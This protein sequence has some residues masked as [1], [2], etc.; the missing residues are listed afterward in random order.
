MIFI[1]YGEKEND[2]RVKRELP[3]F[4]INNEPNLILCKSDE[5]ITTALSIYMQSKEQPLPSS[6]EV[7]LCSS[8][9]KKEEVVEIF[10]RRS[11]FGE[12]G[13][14]HCLVNADLLDFDVSEAAGHFIDECNQEK[15][16][17]K[18]NKYGMVIICCRENE[19]RSPL[20]SSLE[21]Y[22]RPAIPVETEKLSQ[23]LLTKFAVNTGTDQTFASDVDFEKSNTRIVLSERAGVGKSL[24]VKR[25]EEKLRFHVARQEQTTFERVTVPL[26]ERSVNMEYVTQSLLKHATE[27]EIKTARLF[28]IDI[29]HEVQEGIDYLLFNLLVLNSLKDESGLVWKRS[30]SDIYLIEHMPRMYSAGNDDDLPKA[31]MM[32]RILPQVTCLSPSDCLIISE[33]DERTVQ[34]FDEQE[35]K[36]DVFQRPYY[37]LKG[38]DSKLD[39]KLN[40]EKHCGIPNPTWAE[41]H[42]FVWFLN[43]QLVGFE[44]NTFVGEVAVRDLPGFGQFVLRFLIL[45]SKDFSNRSLNICDE[46]YAG[47]QRTELGKYEFRRKWESSP[48]P[49]LFFNSDGVSFTF[50]GFNVDPY[51]GNLID[52]QRKIVLEKNI[53]DESLFRALIRNKVDLKEN[54]DKLPRSHRIEKLANV[55]GGYRIKD[56]DPTYELTTDNAKKIL[57][58]FM[59]FKCDIPVIVMGETGCGKTRLIKFMCSLQVPEDRQLQNTVVMKVLSAYVYSNTTVHGGTTYADIERKVNEADNLAR[60][61]SKHGLNIYTVLFFDEA[62]TTEAIGLLKEIMCDRTLRGLPLNLSP[63]LKIVAACNP[64]RRHSKKLVEK[65]EQAGLGYHVNAEETT[66]TFGQIPLRRLVYRVHPLPQSLWSLV[67]DFGQ[68]TKDV[69][70]LYITQMVKR[71]VSEGKLPETYNLIPVLSEILTESQTFMRQ[72]RNITELTRSLILSLGVCY[73]AR[74]KSREM[75]RHAIE[76]H[77]RAPFALERHHGA[78]QIL[79]E[80]EKNIARNAA[81]RENVFMMVVCIELR[82]PLFLVGKPGSSK[83]VAKTIVSDTLQGKSSYRNLFKSLKQTRMVSFQCS[84]LSSP[85][86]IVATFRQCAQ[87]QKDRN[88]STFVSTVVL[89]EVGLAED[90]PRM[91]LK[92]LHPL[93]EDGCQGDERPEK[94]MKVSFVGLS[95]WAL[96]PAKMNRGIFVQRDVPDEREL[97]ETARGICASSNDKDLQRIMQPLI[98]PLAESYLEVYNDATRVLREFFGLRDFYSLVKMVFAFIERSRSQPTWLELEHCIKRNFGGLQQVDSV[99]RFRARLYRHIQI[100]KKRQICKICAFPEKCRES[101]YPLLLAD[102]FGAVSLMQQHI[103]SSGKGL[104]PCYIFGSSFKGD[105]EYTQICRN[106]NKIKVCMETGNTVVLL[107]LENLYVSL[108][109]ALNQYYTYFGGQRFIDLGL[110]THRVKCQVHPFFR[111]IVVA[112]KSTVYKRFPIP[113]INRLEKH[114]LTSDCLLDCRQQKL[115]TMLKKWALKY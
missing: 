46:S 33:R 15:N 31:E 115:S 78:S 50:L 96:D 113:L 32:Y 73:H 80:I 112:E 109:D 20:M 28:H 102:N 98:K 90:S 60:E 47:D 76:K 65:L 22:I 55:M 63:N 17:Q 9:T 75:Y 30:V 7:L 26:Q 49:F 39:S 12:K 91:P 69:E 48:H 8:T 27:P 62:N 100:R 81:L 88:L 89:D 38:L 70:G 34:R 67:W 3:A 2:V 105:Q 83:S 23:Y 18:E 6:D 104:R 103:L 68:L 1:G 111:L 11:M 92:T 57:A 114:F 52:Q 35:F 41:L 82:I 107:N 10:I 16:Y 97:I 29:S 40:F 44:N 4:S 14:L 53:M 79:H 93:L 61:N 108:Y 101:R 45:M 72:Q 87:F 54:F 66:D 51:S 77:F 19:N 42:H 58:I 59:R 84:P 37:Y 43:T 110:G 64:Y 86:G 56:P 25:V 36:S 85:E 94:N 99:K 74:L 24:F 71:Y 5:T 106:I 13:K 21:K 95:N